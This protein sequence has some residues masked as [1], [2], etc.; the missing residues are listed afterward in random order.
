MG[1]FLA[2]LGRIATAGVLCAGMIVA[3]GAQTAL[4]TTSHQTVTA[5]VALAAP[6]PNCSDFVWV[7]K[8]S[9]YNHY[10][11]AHA[12]W[13]TVTTACQNWTGVLYLDW[14]YGSS[15]RVLLHK[16]IGLGDCMWT[17]QG[18][19]NT[20]WMS[21]NDY[22]DFGGKFTGGNVRARL[23]IYGTGGSANLTLTQAWKAWPGDVP[24]G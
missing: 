16:C 15:Y 3:G 11:W 9:T 17:G 19:V 1:N 21:I 5:Q 13:S 10:F 23:V 24:V 18:R 12:Q 7:Q 22:G 6:A 14:Q 4:A 20:G 2:S 8:D